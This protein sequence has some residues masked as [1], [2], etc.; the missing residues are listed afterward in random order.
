MQPRASIKVATTTILA[1]AV[2]FALV[3]ALGFLLGV[4]RTFFVQGS[5]GNAR[6]VGVLM[7]LPVIVAASWFACR[8]VVRR[9]KVAPGLGDRAIM[10]GIAFVLLLIAELL[11]GAWLFGRTPGEHFAL[12]AQASYAVGLLAQIGFGLMPLI[13]RQWRPN[14]HDD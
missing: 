6:L 1:G 7:E 14:A 3:F 5:A 11:V 10:G 9:Y 4:V 12:Y 8:Y 13:Q 2:Y